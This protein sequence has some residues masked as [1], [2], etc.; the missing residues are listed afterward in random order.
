MERVRVRI[1]GVAVLRNGAEG[2][3]PTLPIG[4]VLHCDCAHRGE[5]LNRRRGGYASLLE[6]LATRLFVRGFVIFTATGDTLPH[7]KVSTAE[8]RVFETRS[9][10]AVGQHENLKRSASHINDDACTLYNAL[11][12]L[13]AHLTMRAQHAIQK[14]LPAATFVSQ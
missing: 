3:I 11:V 2:R 1:Y 12:Q 14:C 5:A 9:G 7:A 8:H 13:Q 10:P 6:G 4:E